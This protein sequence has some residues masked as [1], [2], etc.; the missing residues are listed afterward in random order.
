MPKTP[1]PPTDEP[2]TRE[3]I[4]ASRAMVGTHIDVVRR[5]LIRAGWRQGPRR[6]NLRSVWQAIAADPAECPGGDSGTP[7]DTRILAG[8]AQRIT[9]AC[10]RSEC[11]RGFTCR[12]GARPGDAARRDDPPCFA[13][14]PQ[15]ARI[16]LHFAVARLQDPRRFR[17]AHISRQEAALL[18]AAQAAL[19]D[20]A[21]SEAEA[22]PPEPGGPDASTEPDGIAPPPRP[23][24]PE[25]RIVTLD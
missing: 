22:A 11:R 10:P 20:Q 15:A 16:S 1:A 23:P 19:D 13:A 3:E 12:H 14:L 5:A 9:H 24:M 25:P 6:Q 4:A 17:D 7:S 8:I 2:P 18:R 21:P